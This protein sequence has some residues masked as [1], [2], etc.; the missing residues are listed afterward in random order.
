[1][2]SV[3][4]LGQSSRLRHNH[5]VSMVSSKTVDKQQKPQANGKQSKKPQ[6]EEARGREWQH[7]LN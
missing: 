1:M 6:Y 5:I 3:H 2:Q 4:M 7:T